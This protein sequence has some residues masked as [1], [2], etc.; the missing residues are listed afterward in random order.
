MHALDRPAQDAADD[1]ETDGEVGDE[2]HGSAFAA[3]RAGT[4]LARRPR[5]G[6][7]GEGSRYLWAVS[8]AV[9]RTR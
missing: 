1:V 5:G 9:E 7:R 6:G 2:D 4:R 8:V 3:T